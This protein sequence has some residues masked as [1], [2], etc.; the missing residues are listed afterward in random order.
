MSSAPP[1]RHRGMD[2][3]AVARAT[4]DANRYMTLG[5]ADADGLPWVSP[6][7]F[8]PAGDR[9]FLW[10]SSPETRH[11]RNLAARPQLSIVIF[12]SQAPIGTGQGVYMSALAE[13]LAGDELERGIRVFS[14]RSEANGG[15]PW[16]LEDVAG[17]ARLR[18]Y[19]ATA[20]DQF[21]LGARDERLPVP[22]G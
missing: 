1:R 3:A 20:S 18:L 7:W 5:T 12:D 14:E 6:V 11:S 4:I 15:G 8:A 2:L 16:T 17:A 21:V 19:C 9:R 22:R 13:Q 10:V